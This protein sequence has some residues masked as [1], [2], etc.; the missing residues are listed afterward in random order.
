MVQPRSCHARTRVQKFASG[1]SKTSSSSRLSGTTARMGLTP[2]LIKIFSTSFQT[3][4]FI[5]GQTSSNRRRN[6][7]VG[8]CFTVRPPCADQSIRVEVEACFADLYR[9]RFRALLRA[10]NRF[11]PPLAGSS[12]VAGSARCQEVHRV[13]PTSSSTLA[14]TDRPRVSLSPRGCRRMGRVS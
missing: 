11:R 3:L 8:G 14:T 4:H 2:L 10:R 1:G 6:R 12:L 13:L 5:V 7:G 9:K